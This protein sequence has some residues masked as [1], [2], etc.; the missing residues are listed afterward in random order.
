[1]PKREFKNVKEFIGKH[2]AALDK[3]KIK[4]DI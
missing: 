3:V 1:M 2:S 4:Y